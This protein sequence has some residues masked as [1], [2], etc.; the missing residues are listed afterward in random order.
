VLY[1]IILKIAKGN[2]EK[3]YIYKGFQRE[4]GW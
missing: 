3:E 1:A 4:D 2:E